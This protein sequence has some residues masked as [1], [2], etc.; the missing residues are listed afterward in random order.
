MVPCL[1]IPPRGSM[2][3]MGNEVAFEGMDDG[4]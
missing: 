1:M 3:L 4:S 2:Y